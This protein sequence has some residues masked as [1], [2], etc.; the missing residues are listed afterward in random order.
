M[1][2]GV[3]TGG[4]DV[5]RGIR[6]GCEDVSGLRGGYGLV[7]GDTDG[8]RGYEWDAWVSGGALILLL[9]TH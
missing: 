9:A 1:C 8:A 7:C 5:M 6:T 2:G 3:R 4:E